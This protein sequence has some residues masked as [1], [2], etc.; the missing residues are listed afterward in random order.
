MLPEPTGAPLERAWAAGF[1]DGEGSVSVCNSAGHRGTVRAKYI[2]AECNQIHPEV[3]E[4]FLAAVG[5]GTVRGPYGARPR[6]HYVAHG[7]ER[8]EVMY[9][10]VWPWLGSVKKEQ[11]ERKIAEYRA[12][13]EEWEAIL[14]AGNR[15]IPLASLRKGLVYAP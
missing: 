10:A 13:R 1:F 2:K 9:E 7:I 6:W 11:A 14:P 5:V 12:W 4:R 3:L 15:R 8:V